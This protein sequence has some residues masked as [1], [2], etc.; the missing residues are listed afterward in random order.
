MP[1]I[2]TPEEYDVCIVGSGAGGGMAAHELAKAGASIVLLEAGQDWDAARDGNMLTW[3]YESPRR[4]R[5][6]RERPFG[7][8]DACNGGWDLEGEPYT[9]AEGT[10]WDWFRA[11]MVGGRTHQWGRISLRFGPDDFRRRSIDGQGDD[12]PI[13]YEELEPYYD[14]LDRMIGV[15]GSNEGMYNEPDGVFLPAPRPRCYEKL[16]MAGAGKLKI[17]VIPSRLSIL[18]KPLGDRPACHYCGQCARGCAT[19]SNFSS[20]SVLASRHCLRKPQDDYRSDGPRNNDKRRGTSNGGILRRYNFKGRETGTG[21][22]CCTGG[23][24]L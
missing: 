1:F 24:R 14:R 7:E 20:Q 15:F 5:G 12:W 3:N 10:E 21:K 23:Q 11:R 4:G 17:P 19:R 9:K 8:F 16:I 13:T 6:T 18:T 2:Q 22:N